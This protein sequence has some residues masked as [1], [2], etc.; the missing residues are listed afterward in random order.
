MRFLPL[1]IPALALGLGTTALAQ[2]P[3]S[4]YTS[5]FSSTTAT[6]GY[7]FQAPTMFVVTGLQVP[8]EMNVGSQVVA[9]YK[10]SAAP[11][12]YSASVPVTPVFFA[13][14]TN[15]D[16]IPVVPPVVFQQGDWVGVL[17]AAGAANSTLRNSYGA[18]NYPSRVLGT[19]VTLLRFLMQANI[20]NNSGVGNVSAEGTASI[21]RVRMFVGGQG[22]A[23]TYGTGT[24]NNTLAVSDPLPPSLGFNGEFRVRAGAATNL[25]GVL[26]VGGSRASVPTPWGTLLVN[27]PFLATVTLPGPVPVTGLPITVAIPNDPSLAGVVLTF[28]AGIADTAG[29]ALT[30]GLQWTV[31]R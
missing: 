15:G 17:G 18:G 30:N 13:A 25:G 29:V 21:A 6:R 11:P 7:F 10:M 9:L 2:L 28:Q 31:G 1:A 27:V 5:T 19:P 8:D 14:V 23:V 24:G 20:G 16:V 12:Q 22:A 4:N 3:L 26:L